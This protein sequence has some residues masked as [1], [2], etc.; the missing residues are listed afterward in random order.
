MLT[1]WIWNH[2]PPRKNP[3]NEQPRFANRHPRATPAIKSVILLAG[4]L[5]L[6]ILGSITV[7]PHLE[8]MIYKLPTF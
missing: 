6:T 4:L 8:Q 1:I 3:D 2:I 5:L 7:F